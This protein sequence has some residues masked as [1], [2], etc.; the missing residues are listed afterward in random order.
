MKR[1][2]IVAFSLLLVI[3]SGCMQIKDERVISVSAEKMWNEFE[4]DRD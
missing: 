2:F 4:I 1:F 3:L